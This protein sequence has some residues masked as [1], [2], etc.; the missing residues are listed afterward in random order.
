M[1]IAITEFN[2]WENE[3]WTYVLDMEKQDGEVLNNLM[4][5]IRVANQHFEDV[6]EKS[7]ERLFA[8]SRYN[9]KFYN[10]LDVSDKYPVLRNKKGA[11]VMNSSSGYNSNSYDLSLIISPLRMRSTMIRMR[12]K[13]ENDLYKNFDSLF[14]KTKS[15]CLYKY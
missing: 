3:R 14:L 8:A 11:L 7:T 9:F 5:F 12:D 13:Q 15:K 4:I 6:K 2:A 10:K 1:L